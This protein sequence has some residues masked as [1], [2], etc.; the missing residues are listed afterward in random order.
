MDR[1]KL[2]RLVTA[3][4]VG[5]VIGVSP[6]RVRQLSLGDARFPDPVG[7]MG[8]AMVWRWVD[9]ETWATGG[10]P[11][12]RSPQPAHLDDAAHEL[13]PALRAAARS[14]AVEYGVAAAT[15]NRGCRLRKRRR[16][17]T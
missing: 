5:R 9:V 6:D 4:E 1:G 13:L 7:L 12:A 14:A 3:T 2:D 10:G 17:N 16:S 8:Q 11:D 15:P